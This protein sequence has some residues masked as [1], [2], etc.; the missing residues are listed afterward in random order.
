MSS[1]DY[2]TLKLP[3]YLCGEVGEPFP[4]PLQ[5]LIGCMAAFNYAPIYWGENTGPQG[6]TELTFDRHGTPQAA[7]EAAAW[8]C[9]H[10]D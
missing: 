4:A 7:L 10:G 3:S 2:I 8:F 5:Q 9:T 6:T 1:N